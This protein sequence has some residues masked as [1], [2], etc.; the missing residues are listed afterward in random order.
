M[1]KGEIEMRGNYNTVEE[2]CSNC[3][4]FKNGHCER[5]N[6]D[7]DPEALCKFYKGRE[8]YYNDEN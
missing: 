1:K 7:P 3:A 6:I 2:A 5:N 4:Y 8:A